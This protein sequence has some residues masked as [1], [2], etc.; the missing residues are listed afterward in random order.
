MEWF[1]LLVTLFSVLA[2]ILAWWA[3]IKWSNEF[4]EAKNAAIEAKDALI[5]SL[6]IEIE[7]L[8]E[9]TPLKLREYF[10]S[11]KEQLEEYNDNLHE[12]LEE[13]RR[14]V[15]RR[16]DE[17]SKLKEKGTRQ[18]SDLIALEEERDEILSNSEKLRKQ[19]DQLEVKT[20]WIFNK[21]TSNISSRLF[22]DIHDSYLQLQNSITQNS[23]ENDKNMEITAEWVMKTLPNFLENA[24]NYSKEL[25][26]QQELIIEDVTIDISDVREGANELRITYDRHNLGSL[27][28]YIYH[29]AVMNTVMI[30]SYG[31]QWT[32][33]NLNT[34]KK[35]K[36]HGRYDLM[37]LEGAGIKPGD[38]LKIKILEKIKKSDFAFHHGN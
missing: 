20:G 31:T 29:K 14:E 34:G 25:E 36:S 4:S 6:K 28:D 23:N 32:L 2:A 7:N 3:K 21:E 5:D 1:Y 13:A 30:N 38:K 19:I 16:N 26:N 35:I 17:I 22:H 12:K 11:V 15:K 8:R 10:Q 37:S 27:L 24:I 33:T 9:L 18:E